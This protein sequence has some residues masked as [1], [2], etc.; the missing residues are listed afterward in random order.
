MSRSVVRPARGL[1]Q[2]L[3]VGACTYCSVMATLQVD[4]AD[5]LSGL[6]SE[7]KVILDT[8]PPVDEASEEFEATDIPTAAA[9]RWVK[10]RDVVV[11]LCDLRGSTK[12][13][14]GKHD[15]STARIY[16]SGVEGSV[17]ILREFGADFIDIQ[18]DGAFGVFWGER[19]YERALCAG[20]TIKKFST[21]WTEAL[22]SKFGPE[23]PETG[24]KVGMAS[25]RVLVKAIGTPRNVDEQEAVW[26]G[27]PVNFAAKCAQAAEVDQL[28]STVSVWD[29]LEGNDYI[30][31][32]CGCD[33]EPTSLWRD[34]EVETLPV[35]YRAAARL[36]STWCDSCG[37]AFCAAILRG[38]RKRSDISARARNRENLSA[39]Q[40]ALREK[41]VA[42]ARRRYPSGGRR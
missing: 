42:D 40:R 29:K 24:Y 30:A 32:T 11:V 25:G 2:R 34:I 26:A 8:V 41:R 39:M 21:S 13:G 27:R 12:L 38:E 9:R 20:V 23:L 16:K 3:N 4:L 28:I 35:E 15:T 19:R 22:E 31:Y 5:L 14:I 10:L 18:G 36:D 7:T 6:N 17:R 37:P 1:T 33:S